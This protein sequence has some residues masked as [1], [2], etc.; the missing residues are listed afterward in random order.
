MEVRF[1]KAET[2]VTIASTVEA[3]QLDIEKYEN[4]ALPI[5]QAYLELLRVSK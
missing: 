3:A 2:G 1:N 5:D 4:A